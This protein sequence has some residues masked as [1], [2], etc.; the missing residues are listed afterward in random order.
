MQIYSDILHNLELDI[1][2]TSL[3]L[4]YTLDVIINHSIELPTISSMYR[5]LTV[6]FQELDWCTF[7]ENINNKS[8][9][10]KIIE[11]VNC[12]MVYAL[13]YKGDLQFCCLEMLMSLPST[14]I[15]EIF[16]TQFVEV[17]KVIILYILQ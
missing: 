6:I 14:I 3:W 16:N 10:E 13:T 7:L 5:I 2:T 12:V 11:Y 15:K 4:P 17:V 1:E 8:A 9:K